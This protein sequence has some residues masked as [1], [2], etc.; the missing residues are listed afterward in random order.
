ML[1]LQQRRLTASC[2]AGRRVLSEGQRRW[3]FPTTQSLRDIFNARF[4]SELSNAKEKWMYQ[5]EFSKGPQKMFKGLEVL[6]HEKRLRFGIVQP[7]ED[8]LEG[9]W[10]VPISSYSKPDWKWPWATC[11]NWPFSVKVIYRIIE[12]LGLEGIT[13]GHLVYSVLH[14]K[15]CP[16]STSS[17]WFLKISRESDSTTTRGS[18]CQCLSTLWKKKSFLISNPNL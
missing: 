1:T 14:T 11:C 16:L 4:S 6:L 5:S 18:L 9:L 3:S 10:S 7:A 2:P 15:P 13:E 8:C 17:P 12:F